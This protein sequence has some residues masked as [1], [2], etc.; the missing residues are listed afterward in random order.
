MAFVALGLV[1]L[2][3]IVLLTLRRPLYQAILGGLIMTMLLYGFSPVEAGRQVAK[4]FINWSSLSVLV[5]LYLITYLQRMLEARRQIK[6]AGDDLSGL[7]HNRRVNAIGAPLFIGL[8]P[9]A[10]AMILCGDIV[11]EATDG[12]LEP[13][14]QA[15]VTSWFRH[16]PEST[17]PTYTAVLLMVNLS[18]LPIGKFIVCMIPAVLVL[19]MLGYFPY[20]HRLPKDPGVPKSDRPL[21][22]LVGLFA[23]LWTLLLILV[24]ILGFHFSVVPAVA[25]VIVLAAFVYRFQGGEL[26]AMLKSAFEIKLLLNT[27]LVLVLKEFI[28][29][30]GT[31]ELLPSALAA[32]PIPT[33]LVFALLFFFGGILSGVSGII[34]MGTPLAFAALD[35]GIPLMVLLMCMCHAA[36][37]LSPT[38]VCLVVASDYYGVT[39]GDLIRKTLPRALLF[40]MLMII[41]YNVLILVGVG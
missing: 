14:E 26:L 35:G 28:A 18:G 32:L 16:I 23:H 39:L 7:F 27:F 31:L 15:F 13:R 17:M 19:C 2:V 5:S 30:T 38:H 33:Y 41:Y 9:S 37:Q 36:S 22:H 3:I 21:Q 24:L 8:L 40:C 1:F 6:L 25:I 29:H 34:A 4:V 20:L 12:Y 11:K 10:A